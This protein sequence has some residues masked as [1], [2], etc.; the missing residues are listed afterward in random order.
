L[1][2]YTQPNQDI[3]LHVDAH[4][5]QFNLETAIPL[6]LIINEAV[7]NT[8]KHGFKD[9]LKGILKISIELSENEFYKM[10]IEDNGQGVPKDFNFKKSKSLGTKLIKSLISQLEGNVRIES[11]YP[12][13]AL[14]FVFKQID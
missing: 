3:S 9:K 10:I 8:L 11:A 13:T 7:T 2:S 12:G 5:I 6:G 14:H 1:A 4:A